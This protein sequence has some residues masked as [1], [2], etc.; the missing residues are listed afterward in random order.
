MKNPFENAMT[1]LNKAVE[2]KRFDNEFISLLRQPNRNIS[3]SIPVKMDDG[4]LR[5]FEGYR[6]E[7]SNIL[8]PYKGGIRYHQ[9][10]NLS[11]VKALAFWMTLKCS[12]VNIPMGGGKGG[13]TVNP[14]ELSKAELE[15]LS[16]GW[17]QKMSDI[18]GLQM[19]IRHLRS[20][21]GW[22]TSMEKLLATRLV[23]S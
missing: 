2:I 10:T 7:Y 15:R 16:H 19:S 22:P 13:I 23:R 14:K 1:Q 8:G 20:W 12:V 9:D 11:E 18:I 21:L 17:V 6:V 3:V 5:I 4:S